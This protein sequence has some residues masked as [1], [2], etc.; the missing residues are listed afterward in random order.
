LIIQP[1][2]AELARLPWV[3]QRKTL[4]PAKGLTS[5]AH[6]YTSDLAPEPAVQ[7]E[8]YFGNLRD[9]RLPILKGIESLWRCGLM[10]HGFGL[11]LGSVGNPIL[12]G[13]SW[14]SSGWNIGESNKPSSG[15]THT[16]R[17]PHFGIERYAQEEPK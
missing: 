7:S 5:C 1:S 6:G 10:A 11:T 3:F 4:N 8:E 16:R 17:E 13:F 15:A 14:Y 12:L 2:V 9:N